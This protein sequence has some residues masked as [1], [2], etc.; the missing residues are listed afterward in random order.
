MNLFGA[1]R[2]RISPHRQ[3]Y[4]FI[5][6]V[7]GFYPGNIFLYVLAFRHRSAA[8]E[9]TNGVKDSNERLEFLGDAVF[10]S[11]ITEYLFKRYPFKDEG[12]LTEIRSRI[13]SRTHL[14]KL[15]G[16]LGIHQLLLTDRN[17]HNPN[18]ALN[19]DAFEALVGAIYLDKGFNFVR[20]IILEVV[21]KQHIDI[22]YIENVNDNYKSLI[23]THCQR[24]RKKLEYRVV[25]E[26][27][28]LGRRQ[29]KINLLINDEVIASAQDYSIKKAEQSSSLKACKMLGLINPP[30]S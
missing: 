29:Y 8:I 2:A 20:K 18:G 4:T 5:K 25:E 30:N 1:L 11:I 21:I 17:A 9:L 26:I 28:N 16:R 24:E 3:I 13:V 22:D 23:L 27:S 12:F 14:N 15:S 10:G 19:G 6:N 7:F